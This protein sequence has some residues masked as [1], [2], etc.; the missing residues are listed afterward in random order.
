MT[1]II[2]AVLA[3]LVVTQ[4][5]NLCTTVYLHRCAAH[6]ALSLRRPVVFGFRVVTWITT[7]IRP[8]EWVA[9]HR[10]H[11]AF[12]DVEGD[13]HSPKLLGWKRVQVGNV[14]LYKAEASNPETLA[15]YAKDMQPDAWDRVLFDHAWL[16][17]GIGIAILILLFGP[18]LGL[19]A[20]AVHTVTYLGTNAAVNAVG[21][22][23]GKRPYE[24]TG[25]NVLWLALLTG[26]EGY[27]NNHHAAPTSAHIG[28]DRGQIDLGWW[29]IR[30]LRAFR[31]A[32]VRLDRVV[33]AGQRHRQPVG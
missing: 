3:G 32:R 14:G 2:L 27:H 4:I 22:T 12:T 30:V 29:A 33:L 6:R 15:K 10:K 8:R 21:R 18:W 28:F 24:N 13:P 20:A 19:L 17:T 25:T 26:G 23:F 9:V 16:G 7:G 31:L 1:Q 11:H 5:A